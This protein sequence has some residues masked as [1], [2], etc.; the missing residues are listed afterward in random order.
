MFVKLELRV[1]GTHFY[2]VTGEFDGRSGI[3]LG[4]WSQWLYHQYQ[5][6]TDRQNCKIAI[7]NTHLA[8]RAVT[9]KIVI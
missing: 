1:Q 2:G 3:S 5:N 4:I 9:C 8:V 7:G 6:V